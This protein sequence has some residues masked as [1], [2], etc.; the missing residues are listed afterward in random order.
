MCLIPVFEKHFST[1]L[2]LFIVRFCSWSLFF[3]FFATS[4][5]LYN[6]REEFISQ[7][8]A[9]VMHTNTHSLTNTFS[10]SLFPH[11]PNIMHNCFLLRTNAVFEFV[12]T[13]NKLAFILIC[14]WISNCVTLYSLKYHHNWIYCL[15]IRL[16][17]Q[18][19]RYLKANQT[20]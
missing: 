15:T 16:S 8:S 10:L 20:K 4:N 19:I 3:T 17:R 18:S 2:A 1:H 12:I 5:L 7:Y 13:F 6:S 9:H 14:L 11:F